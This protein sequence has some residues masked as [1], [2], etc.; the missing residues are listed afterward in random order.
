[1]SK[2]QGEQAHNVAGPMCTR[3]RDLTRSTRGLAAR[4]LD[5]RRVESRHLT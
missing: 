5:R 4:E 3:D 2:K 1:M